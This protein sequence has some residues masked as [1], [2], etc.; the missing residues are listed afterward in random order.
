[1]NKSQLEVFDI[2]KL[3]AFSR[4]GVG[5]DELFSRLGHIDKWANSAPNGRGYNTYPPYNIEKISE[6]NY[7]VSLAVAGFDKSDIAITTKDG[8]LDIVGKKPENEEVEVEPSVFV[9]KGIA[10]RDFD[11]HFEL[12]EHVE[13]QD[14]EFN[15]GL[16]VIKLERVVPDAL[17]E[18][19]IKIK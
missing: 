10:T 3:P 6:Y 14:A 4:Y 16:L 2:S 15:E 17:K 13:V 8:R 12:A 5:F 11:L 19:V 18:R 7:I 1:M 9:H